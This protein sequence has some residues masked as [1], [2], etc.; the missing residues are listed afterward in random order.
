MGKRVIL[1]AGFILVV[2][3]LGVGDLLWLDRQPPVLSRSE[4]HDP[5]SGYP[6]KVTFNPMRD[7]SPERVATAAVEAIRQGRCREQLASWF[8]DYRR[9]YAQFICRA[10]QQHPLASYQLFDREERPPLVILHYKTV[11][12][13]SGAEY[14]TY[15]EDLF[16]TTQADDSGNWTVTKYGAL[17]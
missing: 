7:R 11:R 3:L 15:T 12:R 16:I 2:L 5:V 9:P 17:Y 8:R 13:N 6:L 10:E 4:E 14:D 1:I